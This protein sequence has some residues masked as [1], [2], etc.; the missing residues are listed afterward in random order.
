MKF[1]W[2]DINASYS[3]S[4]LA[5]PAL[6]A[7]LKEPVLSA[8][9]WYAVQ[10]TIKT[11]PGQILS[12]ILEIAPDYIFATGW[13]FN[14]E[15]LLEILSKADAVGSFK[16]IFLGGPEF[17]G[18]NGRFLRAHPFI[19]AVFKGEGEEMFPAFI[20]HLLHEKEDPEWNRWK[21]I[22]G[23]EYL[24]GDRYCYSR[25]VTVKNFP[26]LSI[27]ENSPFFNWEKA[28]VQ[29]ETSRGCFNTCRFCV[30]GI[31]RAPVQN[32]PVAEL[33]KRL[34]N[35]Q[36][37]NIRE[38]RIL[39]RTFNANTPRALEMLELFREFAGEIQ[40]HI[41]VHPALLSPQ[42][43]EYFHTLPDKL[44][45][46]EAGIQS[47]REPVIEGCKR[48][49]KSKE[50]LAGLKF[51]LS[52]NKFEVHADLIAGLP[53]YTFGEL[54]E[55]T[56]E[57][58]DTGSQEIQLELLKVLPGTY[59]REHAATFGLKYSPLPPY[60]VLQTPGISYAELQNSMVLSR[61]ID[62]W[63][64]DP[65]WRTVFCSVFQQKKELLR[66]FTD[67]LSGTEIMTQPLSFESRSLLLYDFCKQYAREEL[68]SV[69]LQWIR[70][71]LS[72]KKEPASLLTAWNPRVSQ[73]ENPLFDP[74][75]PRIKYY[76]T[77]HKELIYWF[78]YDNETE[79][80]KPAKELAKQLI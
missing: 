4:S 13:L 62:Y 77:V 67:T 79:R 45:H 56:L 49:G 38:V 23:F 39:D 3:H 59:F 30:S 8:C 75:N 12:E 1:L 37:H 24:D 52:V 69:S 32:I 34:R 48:A 55:D 64:N 61:I 76:Y 68:F 80:N 40:F 66:Q 65:R 35:I 2:L 27:P 44:L 57:L 54:L 11:N 31:E 26:Q 41:E 72:L 43:K 29:L 50:A 51:L 70:N 17:L 16:G 20:S 28:F 42:L 14:I 6:H 9:N 74:R 71:G 73:P 36:R 78:S 46:V 60:E 10:G 33:R 53:G 5:L 22:P 18:D 58:M 47:L 15:R 21:E 25:P 63:Y 7:Q 19:T